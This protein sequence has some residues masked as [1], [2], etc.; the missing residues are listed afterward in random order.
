VTLTQLRT[1]A[2]QANGVQRAWINGKEALN[3][4]NLEY[5]KTVSSSEL[6]G[7]LHWH[8]Y[9]GGKTDD[10]APVKNQSIRCAHTTQNLC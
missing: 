1:D 4:N 8:V 2:G 3:V 9:H 6:I 7:G 5:R 10:W